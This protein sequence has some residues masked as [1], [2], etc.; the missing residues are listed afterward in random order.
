MPI[1]KD[2]LGKF[3]KLGFN[4]PLYKSIVTNTTSHVCIVNE[5]IFE[6]CIIGYSV[7]FGNNNAAKAPGRDKAYKYSPLTLPG[8]NAYQKVINMDIPH[9]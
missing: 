2:V 9:K 7:Q 5:L 1:S 4:L 8:L 6:K 3:L